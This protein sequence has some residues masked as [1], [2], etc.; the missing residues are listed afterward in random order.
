VKHGDR[1]ALAAAI[2][3]SASA[4][5]VAKSRATELAAGD[6]ARL[7][8][9]RDHNA[10]FVTVTAAPKVGG[11]DAVTSPVAQTV[12]AVMTEKQKTKKQLASRADDERIAREA[13]E[14]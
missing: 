4:L 14:L 5:N 10:G 11:R 13:L 1:D 2:R 9:M 12:R 3:Y 8:A 7:D 6:T